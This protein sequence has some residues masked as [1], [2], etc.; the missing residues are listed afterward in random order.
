[1]ESRKYEVIQGVLYYEPP[2]SPG[3]LC[4]V[5]P[6]KLR[7]D[8]MCEAHATCLAGHFAFKKVYDRIRRHYWWKDYVLMCID[9]VAP[10]WFVQVARAR[11]GPYD[12]LSPQYQL[13]DPFIVSELTSFNYQRH[14]TETAT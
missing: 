9:F 14:S 12:Q 6:A 7:E 10:A 13:E 8:L 2:T 1:M 3:K 11:V 5:V 4:V